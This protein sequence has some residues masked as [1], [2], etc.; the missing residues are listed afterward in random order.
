MEQKIIPILVIN[1]NG[2]SDTEACIH[3]LL[4]Q[5]YPATHIMVLDNLSDNQ[6]Y[7]Q[8][9]A[10]FKDVKNVE[11]IASPQNLGFA[12]GSNYLYELFLK[13]NISHDFL[14][15]LNNDAFAEKNWLSELVLHANTHFS[16]VV[17]TKM[18]RYDNH[19]L[20]DNIGHQFINTA[21]IVPIAFKENVSDHNQIINHW[22][23]CAGACLYRAS[24]IQ[25]IG[26]FDPFFD[27]GY[28]DAEYGLRARIA[29]YKCSFAPQAKVYH[30]IS[31]SVDKIM[32]LDYKIRIQINIFYSYFK[33]M[34]LPFLVLNLPF[35]L[36][37]Y[38]MVFLIDIVSFRWQFFKV[39][40]KAI[41]ITYK[42]HK[43]LIKEK[44]KQFLCN[45]K[46]ISFITIFRESTFFLWFDIKRFWNLVVRQDKS[47]FD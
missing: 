34:P 32:N 35:M 45:R 3:S 40:Q 17:S 26:L 31:Q 24:M 7:E 6:E 19:E 43:A 38:G 22:G 16:D 42:N 30:K 20:L 25:D 29:G 5:D 27:T 39:M 13:K 21:E 46:T 23:A 41:G 8:L 15:M 33:L 9:H 18:I 10:S 37:K 2:I 36:F 11:I 12:K 4:A 47:V 1:W 28:E 44:R 14:A